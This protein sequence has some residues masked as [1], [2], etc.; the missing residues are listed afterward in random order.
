MNYLKIEGSSLSNGKGWRVVLWCAGC[1]HQCYNCHN[2][3][4]W[5]EHAGKEFTDEQMDLILDLLK[6]SYIKGL[7]L[8]G[9]DPLFY[10]NRETMAKICKT[11]KEVYPNKDIWM[12]T[13]FN[14]N[15]VKNLE[16]LDYVD[17]LIDGLFVNSLRDVSLAFRGSSNQKV[18]NVPESRKAGETICMNVD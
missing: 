11:V 2:P 16:V 17:V 10:N 14:Y 18:I 9:G 5:N 8:S 6:P 1:D 3:E 13:G 12:Y 15:D 4:S 7:T